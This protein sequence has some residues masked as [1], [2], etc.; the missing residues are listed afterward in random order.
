MAGVLETGGIRS[1]ADRVTQRQMAG[2]VHAAAYKR[3]LGNY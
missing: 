1:P 2:A 3:R